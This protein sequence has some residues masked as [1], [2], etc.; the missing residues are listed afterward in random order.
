M[1]RARCPTCLFQNC[2]LYLKKSGLC[3]STKY[4]KNSFINPLS[5]EVTVASNSSVEVM[6]LS[7][8]FPANKANHRYLFVNLTSLAVSSLCSSSRSRPSYLGIGHSKLRSNNA[9]QPS[10]HLS[11]GCTIIIN[12]NIHFM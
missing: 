9:S 7:R 6:K 1:Q 12:A 11:N 5:T 10:L 8:R 4:C 2:M 3:C